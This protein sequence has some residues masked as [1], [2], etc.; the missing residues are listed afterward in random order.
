MTAGQSDITARSIADAVAA[1]ETIERQDDPRRVVDEFAIFAQAFGFSTVAVGQL[2]S[3]ALNRDGSTIQLSTWPKEWADYWVHNRLIVSDP[4]AKMALMQN[5]PFKWNEAFE[6]YK[7]FSKPH[8]DTLTEFGFS[9]GIAI[10]VHTGDDPP[11]C[12]SLGSDQLDLTPAQHAT[13]ELAAIHCYVKLEK[14]YGVSVPKIIRDLTHRESEI[15]HFVAAGKTNWEIGQILSLSE[16]YVHDCLKNIF[17]KLD[18]VSRA[19]AVSTAIREKII[20]L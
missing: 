4:I 7:G 1:I 3:P 5:R 9:N 17:K 14:L 8:R 6:R 13:I 10:P 16:H 15:L 19:H 11:G 18:A 2:A 20:F 12:I